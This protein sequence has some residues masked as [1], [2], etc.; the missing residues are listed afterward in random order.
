MALQWMGTACLDYLVLNT[1]D[2]S[3]LTCFCRP[4]PLVE[5]LPDRGGGPAPVAYRHR[6]D[7]RGRRLRDAGLHAALLGLRP[8]ERQDHREQRP[9][10]EGQRRRSRIK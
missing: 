4:L 3:F 5:G 7:G 8:R 9:Q 6:L 1:R 2:L 10:L